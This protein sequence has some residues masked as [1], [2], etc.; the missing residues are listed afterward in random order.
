MGKLYEGRGFLKL[1]PAHQWYRYHHLFA[2]VLQAHALMEEPERHPR[3]HKLASHWYEE[4]NFF[5]DAIRHSL[6]SQDFERAARATAPSRAKGLH[7]Q[8]R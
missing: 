2:D 8:P 3:L 7:R 4:H 1:F 6:E 5:S